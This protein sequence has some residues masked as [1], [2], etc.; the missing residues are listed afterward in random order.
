MLRPEPMVRLQIM[1]TKKDVQS[2]IDYLYQAKALD[3]KQHKAGEADIGKP[4]DGSEAISGALIKARTI[5]Y[6][7]NLP[8]VTRSPRELDEKEYKNALA[9][10]DDIHAKVQKVFGDKKRISEQRKNLQEQYDKLKELKSLKV[11]FDLYRETNHISYVIGYIQDPETFSIKGDNIE[12]VMHKNLVAVFYERSKENEVLDTVRNHGLS[13]FKMPTSWDMAA[14]EKELVDLHREENKLDQE[15][16]EL[17]RKHQHEITSLERTLTIYSKKAEAPLMFGET[18]NVTVI[19]GWVPQ[20]RKSKFLSRIPKETYVEELEDDENDVPVKIENP[21]AIKPYEFLLEMFSHPSYKEIDPTIF[22][23][24]TFPLFFG[25]MLGDIGYGITTLL[26]FNFIK[27]KNPSMAPLLNVMIFSAISSIIFGLI[28]GEFF[29]FEIA[30][31]GFIENFFHS[32]H[33]HYP[34]LHRSAESVMQLIGISL[35]VGF[36]HVNLG[37]LFGFYNVYKAH[38]LKHAF[39]EKGAWV[40][41]QLG[42]LFIFLGNQYGFSLWYGIIIAII[43]AIMLYKGEGIPGVIEI[44]T[45]FIHMG[46]YMRLMAIGL[47]SVGLA[48]VINDQAAPLFSQGPLMIIFGI[49]IFVLGHTI[50]IGLGVLGP[51]L[52]SLRLHYVEH[53]TKFYKGG[54]RKYQPFGMEG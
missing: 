17:K 15:I 41:M 46:S 50:N 13:E 21:K 20:K 28:Y 40:F 11:P 47:A 19:T 34:F 51:F 3:I 39:L 29:G 54:G 10:I 5:M 9:Y 27:K 14:L 53:F 44:P 23:F 8:S 43:S 25:F 52:H 45:F 36:V 38:G 37:V 32:M 12:Y 6:S 16:A 18:R 2:V 42:V 1:C 30:H 22:M 7:L 26:L 31:W 4:L 35:I 24:I 49:I 33:L 48:V